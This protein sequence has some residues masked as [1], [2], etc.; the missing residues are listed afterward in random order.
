MS[1]I[2][3]FERNLTLFERRVYEARKNLRDQRLVFVQCLRQE[4]QKVGLSQKQLAEMAAVSSGHLSNVERG[5]ESPSA[6]L[7]KRLVEAIEGVQ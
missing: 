2:A 3:V 7:R 6:S 4:R 1:R 5:I